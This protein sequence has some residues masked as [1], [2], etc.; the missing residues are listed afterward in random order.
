MNWIAYEN[1]ELTHSIDFP[2]LWRATLHIY[3]R[4]YYREVS[5]CPRANLSSA[6]RIQMTSYTYICGNTYIHMYVYECFPI[7][8]SSQLI[9][10][11]D[12]ISC[13]D[14]AKC[15]N[16]RCRRENPEQWPVIFYGS[17]RMTIRIFATEYM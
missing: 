14:R 6:T 2:K 12:P 8:S 9:P 1:N 15:G 7:L 3:T 11:E 13:S 16:K 5:K 17:A 10:Q 4:M